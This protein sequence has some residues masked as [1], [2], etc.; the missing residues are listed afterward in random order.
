MVSFPFVDRK[1]WVTL[2]LPKILERVAGY[3]A[4]TAGA[5]RVRA[6][7][8]TADL[9]EARRRQAETSEARRLLAESSDVSFG[10]VH[11]IRE[12]VDQAEHGAVLI[13]HDLLHIRDT[14][15]A[16][17]RL[18]RRL[19]RLADRYPLLAALAERLEDSPVVVIEIS[20]ALND[21]GEVVDEASPALA[22]IRR[23]LRIAQ[24]RLQERLQSLI[25]HPNNLPFLQEALITQRSGRYVIPLKTEF[26]GRI[27]GIVHD[28]SASGATLFIEPL[29]TVELNNRVREL[30]LAEENEIRRILT[31]LSRF[32][33]EEGEAIRRTL[34]ALAELDAI[35]ARAQYAEAIHATTPDLVDFRPAPAPHPGS[36]LRLIRARHPL[37]D[38]QR[39]VPIDV[40][41]DEHTY[42]LVI[43]GPNTG[44]KTVSLKTV[45]L[46]ALMAQVGLHLPAA[47]AQL[48]V[49]EDVFAD[50]G[51]EQSIEQN[52]ST[53]SSHMTNIVRILRQSGLRALVILDELG[54]GTDPTEGSALA[55]A[56]LAALLRRGVTTLV[57]T[58]YPEL[59][60]FAHVT[61]GVQNA[62]LEFDLETLAPTYHLMIGLPGRSNAF[63]IA[64]RLGL[65]PAIIVEARA[66]VPVGDL[67]AEALLADIHETRQEM[68]QEQAAL[69]AARARVE[70]LQAEFADRLAHIDAERRAILEQARAEAQAELEALRTEVRALR[71]RLQAAAGGRAAQP[72]LAELREVEAE[73]QALAENVQAHGAPEEDALVRRPWQ[74]G[75]TVWLPQ[76]RAQGTITALDG[77][78]AEVQLGRLRVR[79][80]TAEL[81]PPKT[82]GGRRAEDGEQPPFVPSRCSGQAVR[83]P[84]SVTRPPSPGL[85]LHLRGQ[86]VDEA[87]AALDRYL[88]A[89]YLAGLPWV[90]I[91]HGK[92]TGTLRRAVRRE[93]ARHP[94]V[95]SYEPARDEEGGEGVTVV[96]L[97]VQ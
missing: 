46:L 35:F 57:A 25:T 30:E 45:G 36:T 50:I 9:A 13:P 80:R 43:T 86:T 6:L 31:A 38:P 16:A 53:F 10:G 52:L 58:H 92:G 81:E 49:F 85:E 88:N 42:A 94:L 87:L 14:L 97:A 67:E 68:R 61:P 77:E 60:V 28:Q 83:R 74:V 33:A 64:E 5:E 48:S 70:A 41:L 44:G 84:S 82:D 3:A 23:D 18:R 22:Q 56:I 21:Q 11:D 15:V 73:A 24:H 40:V 20:R 7:E 32:V 89:A 4:F 76:V 1:S 78:E 79:A 27:P 55:R 17:Q 37:L 12:A 95:L 91:V 39:V 75:D 62:S 71:R 66:L 54:A 93:L 19:T 51:D 8:P 63:A 90:R 72:R 34:D 65:D 47:E 59:K 2:E 69:N 96:K 26:K 29:V